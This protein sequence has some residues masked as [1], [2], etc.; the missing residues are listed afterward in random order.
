[1]CQ[2]CWE[3]KKGTITTEETYRALGEMINTSKDESQIAHLY[4]LSEEILSKE[5]PSLEA[6]PEKDFVWANENYRLADIDQ[7]D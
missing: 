1:M 6:D 7:E 3:W 4:E 2:L 5:A